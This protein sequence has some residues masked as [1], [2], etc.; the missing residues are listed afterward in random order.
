[1]LFDHLISILSAVDKHDLPGEEAQYLLSPL[2]RVGKAEAMKSAANVRQSA[3]LLNFHPIQGEAFLSLIK[4]NEYPGVHSGQLSFPGGK[5]ENDDRDL[6][7][8]ALRET[9]EELGVDPSAFSVIGELTELFI[10]PSSFLVQPFLS[11]S[12]DRPDFNPDSREVQEHLEIPMDIFLEEEN[13]VDRVVTSSFRNMR[14]KTKAIKY[15]EHIIWGATAMMIS[16]LRVI[17]NQN[18]A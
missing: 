9:E 6:M 15:N 2:G 13:I 3:V 11:Y 12:K 17:L 8:T 18:E 10:P 7:H 16:E 5:M 14:I 1:M 4:R